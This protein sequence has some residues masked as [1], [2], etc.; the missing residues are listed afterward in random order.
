MNVGTRPTFEG[1]GRLHAEAHLIDFKGDVY[2]RRIE[3]SFLTHLR[4]ERRFS[5]VEALREQ[6]ASD[7]GATRK[8]LGLP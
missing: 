2:G 3:M 5:D 6:I 7:V 1:D 8:I 4:E